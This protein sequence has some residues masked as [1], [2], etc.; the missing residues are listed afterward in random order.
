MHYISFKRKSAP[1]CTSVVFWIDYLSITVK[2]CFC[3]VPRTVSL[4]PGDA[5][6]G[7]VT[8]V[9]GFLLLVGLLVQCV[10]VL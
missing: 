3:M 4:E 10:C 5:P 8:S 2:A 1:I 9:L 6:P 7:Y